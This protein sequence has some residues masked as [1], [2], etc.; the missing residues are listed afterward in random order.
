MALVQCRE[1]GKEVS[2]EAA[3]CP[4]CGVPR[5]T[6]PGTAS[7]FSRPPSAEPARNPSAA[8]AQTVREKNPTR[9][10]AGG[11]GASNANVVVVRSATSRGL[12]IILGL[13]LGC[14]GIHNFYAGYYGRGAVQLVITVL[15]GWFIIGF[16]ITALWAL[17]EICTVKHDGAGIAMT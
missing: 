7:P 5:P 10:G 6:A 9:E 8:T 3:S 12:Y 13:F 16:I 17:F 4:H 15:L 14:L 2:T 1:C 11:S